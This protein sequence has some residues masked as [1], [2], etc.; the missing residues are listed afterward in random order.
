MGY[1]LV[2][3][4]ALLVGKRCLEGTVC[5]TG[6][7]APSGSCFQPWRTVVEPWTGLEH[8]APGG[9]GGR[10]NTV[11]FWVW[12]LGLLTVQIPGCTF[13]SSIL[14]ETALQQDLPVSCGSSCFSPF[15]PAEVFPERTHVDSSSYGSK[16]GSWFSI[17]IR[18]LLT[19]V[20]LSRHSIMVSRGSK[21][22]TWPCVSTPTEGL[23]ET[24]RNGVKL[25][26]QSRGFETWHGACSN[27]VS[28]SIGLQW[29][30]NS[31]FL[32]I[33]QVVWMLQVHGTLYFLFLWQE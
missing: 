18:L 21:R 28:D 20:K 30:W 14:L 22:T 32:T 19:L 4:F 12:L 33:S 24:L 11:W 25:L 23:M 10:L 27:A 13:L 9:T 29:A 31:A 1:K 5:Q 17:L 6:G 2:E 7:R 26:P 8:D 15:H 16:D 3:I